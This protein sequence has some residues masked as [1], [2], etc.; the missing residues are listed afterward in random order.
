MNLKKPYFWDLKK[1][2][3]ISYILTPFTLPIILRNFFFNL[4][5]KKNFSKIK[6]ICIGNIYLGGTGKTP[7]TIKIFEILKKHNHKVATVKKFYKNQIDEQLLL[8]EATSAIISKSRKNAL[9]EGIKNKYEILLFDDGLQDIEIDYD[10]KIVCFKINN[11]IGNGQLIPAG[12]LREKIS[13]L[14]RF[15]ALFLNGSNNNIHEYTEQIKKINPNIKIF[16]SKYR[17]KNIYKYDLNSEYL[18]FSGIGNPK[19]F[20]TLMLENNF[21]IKKEVLF[22]DH[23][24]YSSKNLEDILNLAKNEKL[25]IMTTSKDYIKLPKYYKKEISCLDIDLEIENQN[26]LIDFLIN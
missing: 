22:T 5:K 1:P 19:D 3:Y 7:L 10:K 9:Y 26:E 15:D 8:K 13:S 6:T 18:I 14:K 21:K 4:L 11:W 17:I 24:N 16:K 12:P 20:K 23:F 25:K 2:N